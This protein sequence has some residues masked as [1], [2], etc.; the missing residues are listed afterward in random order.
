M[1]H[2]VLFPVDISYGSSGGPRRSTDIYSSVSGHESRNQKWHDSRREYNAGLGAKTLSQLYEVVS[3]F[4]ERRGQ[5][6]SFRWL[7]HLDY[8]S[9]SPD[10]EVSST[11]QVIGVGDG[12]NRKFQLVKVYGNAFDPW[13]RDI[14]KP[15]IGTV[16]TAINGVQTFARNVNGSTGIVTFDD[17][18]PDT[19]IVTAGF[20]FHVPVRFNTDF[21]SASHETFNHGNLDIPI[22]EVRDE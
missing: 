22:I 17:P 4:E 18:V 14:T 9:T 1:F 19:A 12:A 5:L 16:R 10:L 21:I 8:K 13:T 3:F 20:E 7:D 2:D 6:Y 11:D 15:V